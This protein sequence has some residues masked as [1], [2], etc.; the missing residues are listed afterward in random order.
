MVVY[1]L[2]D[3]RV[4]PQSV[5]R[6]DIQAHVSCYRLH[7]GRQRYLLKQSV[8]AYESPYPAAVAEVYTLAT[9]GKLPC[10]R[11]QFQ[12][13]LP[14]VGVPRGIVVV[15]NLSVADEPQVAV[16]VSA[17]LIFRRQMNA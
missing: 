16:V 15:K 6:I 17:E 12:V 3:G 7:V 1:V 13:Y 4:N 5:F 14:L 10:C 8:L 2:A 11:A 9:V